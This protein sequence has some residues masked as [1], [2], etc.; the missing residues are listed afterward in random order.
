VEVYAPIPKDLVYRAP[1][2]VRIVR[3]FVFVAALAIGATGVLRFMYAAPMDSHN[4][5]TVQT[6][7]G[8]A[9]VVCGGDTA[10]RCGDS[11]GLAFAKCTPDLMAYFNS[12]AE[13]DVRAR[14]LLGKRPPTGNKWYL[15]CG[16]GP[17]VRGAPAHLESN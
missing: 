10:P 2:A 11:T 12:V 15:L 9:G 13:Y 14:A 8:T 16:W 5:G 4:F 7:F 3:T 6:R 17:L 1:P